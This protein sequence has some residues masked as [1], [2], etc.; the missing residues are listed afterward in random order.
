[1][2]A[3]VKSRG[4]TLIELMIS[5]GLGLLITL[6]ATQLFV[7]SQ[8]TASFQRGMSDVQTSG[9][10]ALDKM[11]GDLRMAGMGPAAPTNDNPLI[12]PVVFAATEVPGLPAAST[13]ISS[14][15]TQTAG[16]TDS[17]QLV[18]R[19][20]ADTDTTTD[21]EGNLVARG[22]YVINRY[23]LRVD[24]GS[25]ALACD[26]GSYNAKAAVVSNYGD[27]GVVLVPGVDSFQVLYGLD[28]GVNG[29]ASVARYMNSATYLALPVAN[30]RPLVA[31]R[32]ALYVHSL[33]RAG[34]TLPPLNAVL[35]GDESI[36][37]SSITALNDGAMR[38]LF[39]STVALRNTDP[40][41]V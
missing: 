35:V 11:V 31:V 41:G 12:S 14:N 5:L 36:P 28:D 9:R 25:N 6:A 17:D 30:R 23:F 21:C 27:A 37:V 4:F 10:F 1:M 15:N 2:N 32:V 29:K 18:I 13:F 7:S 34:E 16:I 33:E 22:D 3:S 40:L 19:F 38:R 8:I 20:L 24:G 39:V 26:G